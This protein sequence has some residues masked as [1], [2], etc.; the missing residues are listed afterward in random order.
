MSL[1]C[2]FIG[3]PIFTN[4]YNN[5]KP[6]ELAQFISNYSFK[7]QYLIYLFTRL[8]NTFDDISSVNGNAQRISE[9]FEKMTKN[10]RN[11]PPQTKTFR[12]SE[13]NDNS[14][15]FRIQNLTLTVPDK[16][17]ILIKDLNL[18]FRQ[19]KNILITGRSGC[20]KT[21]LFRSVSGLWTYY[22]GEI[23]INNYEKKVMDPSFLFFLPQKPYFSSPGSLIDQIV[24]P[25]LESSIP[26]TLLATL[27]LNIKEWLHKF[28]LEHLIE[29]VDSD[30]SARP[31]FE[32]P[33]VLS[34]GK[35]I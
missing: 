18:E 23:K 24:Y 25:R 22:T 17:T 3:I 15:C 31:T 7:C 6:E 1:P 20:G 9:L 27:Q 29:M 35:K 5:L 30:L 13:P 28:N 4:V 14:L 11:K 33:S 19:H 8:F 10:L 16:S 26:E 32:W 12:L 34:P 2:V 21:S